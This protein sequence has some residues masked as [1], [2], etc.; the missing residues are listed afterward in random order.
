MFTI[1][2]FVLI[3]VYTRAPCDRSGMKDNNKNKNKIIDKVSSK[4]NETV[5]EV[6]GV[7]EG[8]SDV[9]GCEM[10]VKCDTIDV[11]TY[12]EIFGGAFLAGCIVRLGW[13]S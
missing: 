11:Q 5:D 2:F 6:K 8:A 7:L 9:T 13:S 3:R 1:V 4:A 12:G 10:D